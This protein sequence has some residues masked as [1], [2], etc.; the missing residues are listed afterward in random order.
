MNTVNT[1]EVVRL[2]TEEKMSQREIGE[3]LGVNRHTIGKYLAQKGVKARK[4]GESENKVYESSKSNKEIVSDDEKMKRLFFECIPINEIAKELGVGRRAVER[5]VKE[6][7][8]VRPKSMM[9]RD[10]YDDSKDDDI[11]KMYNDGMCPEEIGKIV[12]LSR[13]AVKNHLKHCGVK[14][15]D[16]SEGLFKANGKDFPEILNNHDELYDLYVIQRLSKL[17]IAKTYNVAPHVVDRCLKKL[18]I[19]VRGVSECKFGLMSKEKHPNWKGGVCSLYARLRQYFKARQTAKVLKRD[20]YKCQIC[21]SKHK[22]QVHH[23]K[24]FKDIFNEIISEHPNLNLLDNE[25]ELFEIMINDFRFN[26]LDN[27]ITYCKECHLFKVHGY[28]KH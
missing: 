14:L 17:D 26:D 9:S 4:P 16:I 13:A 22:L 21:G 25:D 23:I 10:Q 2:Y 8:L 3:I 24:Y 7:G 19:H 20:E 12:G 18:D 15:R 27:L 1:N 28:K 6:L 5:R 11:I